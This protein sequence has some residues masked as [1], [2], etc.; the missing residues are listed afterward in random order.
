M[1]SHRKFFSILNLQTILLACVLASP[2]VWA[3]DEAEAEEDA[4]SKLSLEEVVVTATY[5]STKLMDTAQSISALSESFIEDMGASD[6]NDLFQY[7]P[8]LNMTQAAAGNNRYV[9][10]GV[11]SQTGESPLSITAS[12]VAVYLGEVPV[13][14]SV[15]SSVQVN[16][17]LFDIARVEVL[18][19]PQGTLFGEGS[20]GGMIRYIFNKPDA[21]EFD[22]NV[23][24]G[25]SVMD[26]SSDNGHKADATINLPLIE[27]TLAFRLNMFDTSVA[28]WIDNNVPA[29]KDFNDSKANGARASFLYTPNDALSIEGSWYHVNQ[30]S[31]GIMRSDE[32][33]VNDSG[34]TPGNPPRS[35]DKFD[36][37][38]LVFNYDMGWANFTSST[39]YTERDMLF[40]HEYSRELVW[41]IDLVFGFNTA[42]DWPKDINSLESL[43]NRNRV[44]TERFTQEFRLVSDENKRFRY[45]AGVF[46]KDSDDLYDFYLKGYTT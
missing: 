8:G 6:M 3:Q 13:T 35:S 4:T 40:Y 26:K 18:K 20:Q 5:R 14:S 24:M 43:L 7:V 34:R 46:Y 42:Y 37:Y 19:G 39:S 11:T 10:R 25:Y 9:V 32:N 23:N 17:T 28:G 16:S 27:N 36:I 45:T 12:A 15:G 44:I 1:R 33:Y 22:A 38:N 41:L 21:T 29:E 31:N 2:T 30:E